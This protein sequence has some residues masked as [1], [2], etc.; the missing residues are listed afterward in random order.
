MKK[1]ISVIV[2]VAIVLGLTVSMSMPLSVVAKDSGTTLYAD[3]VKTAPDLKDPT[4]WGEPILSYDTT[5]PN[6][7]AHTHNAAIDVD[8]A[9][10]YISW[11]ETNLYF[12]LSSPETS[13][14]GS[15]D[16][17][18]WEGDGMQ[19]RIE[20]GDVLTNDK[21]DI[22]ITFKE[23]LNGFHGNYYGFDCS[24]FVKDNVMYTMVA[25]PHEA[26]G[27]APEEVAPAAKYV[28]DVIRII[29][30]KMND[31]AGWL[32]LGNFFPNTHD[33]N[34][35]A[36]GDC[37]V[38]LRD[39]D[40]PG[41]EFVTPV[42]TSA[43]KN[44]TLG[45]GYA[46]VHGLMLKAN[47]PVVKTEDGIFM[48]YTTK[49]GVATSTA[50][51]SASAYNTFSLQKLDEEGLGVELAYGYTQ[52]GS[53]D[54]WAD[55]KTGDIYVVAGGSTWD[56]MKLSGTYSYKNFAEK[57]YMNIWTYKDGFMNEII[58]QLP[59]KNPSVDGYKFAYSVLDGDKILSA[60]I[61]KLADDTYAM[62][63]FK[64]D[65]RTR[66]WDED[67]TVTNLGTTDPYEVLVP[68]N[69]PAA[70]IDFNDG[71]I[72]AEFVPDKTATVKISDTDGAALALV[73]L[74]DKILPGTLLYGFQTDKDKVIIIY[75][76][77]K[78]EKKSWY[79]A[80]IT[81]DLDAE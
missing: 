30:T 45:S 52:S 71:A 35:N 31:Y 17:S 63:T 14:R 68:D 1:Y 43:S 24:L 23:K 57:A 20:R 39:P 73:T 4:T 72:W 77:V 80:I 67:S 41:A 13:L 16:N 5:T 54:I 10:L 49:T 18:A 7:S 32:A 38:I 27:F 46:S 40:N 56:V 15:P 37:F 8:S 25:L 21:H 28:F 3:K 50:N 75:E 44:I 42:S 55:E 60:Y 33:Y 36:T 61:G 76:G 81:V 66:T 11:D 9:K 51:P 69:E 58:K 2:S 70:L 29:G 48:V 47:N 79:S 62:E 22:Y 19:L 12:G 34:D 78:N 64:F 59:F 65:I 26:F 74:D 53:Q 6:V